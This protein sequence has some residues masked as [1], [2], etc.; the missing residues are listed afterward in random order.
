LPNDNRTEYRRS[1]VFFAEIFGV[2][3]DDPD[4]NGRNTVRV[5]HMSDQIWFW[6][7]IVSP[8]MASLAA[9]LARRGHEVIYVA[10]QEMTPQRAAQGWSPTS[11][12][13]ASLRLVPAASSVQELVSH[14]PS[15]SIH[16][17]QGLRGN[18]LVSVAQKVL[19][20]RGLRQWVIMETV[21]DSGWRGLLKRLEYAR[22]L[23]LWRQKVEGALAI[24]SVTSQWLVERG[25]PYDRVFPFAYFL[26]PSRVQVRS[27]TGSNSSFRFLFVG[28]LIELKRVDLLLSA[29]SRLHGFHFEFI[30]VGS[31]PLERELRAQADK[32]LPGRVTFLGQ[33]GIGEISSIMAGADCLVLPSRYDGWGAVVS[34]A[35]MVGTPAICSDACGSSVVVRASGHGGVFPSGDSTALAELLK[36]VLEKGRLMPDQRFRLAKWSERLGADAGAHYLEAILTHVRSPHFVASPAAP[37]TIGNLA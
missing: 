33:R 19:A 18:G 16:I 24:G 13:G 6:Q 2:A 5:G 10:E 23:R 14:A 30:I 17:C 12:G 31:G 26:P 21:D 4:A 27:S 3:S 20:K 11:L 29:I 28:R 25:M 8:H 1:N 34:E 15:D 32:D 7:R 22:L 35:L 37:W 9:A 36:D